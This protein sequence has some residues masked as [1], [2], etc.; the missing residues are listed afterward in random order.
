LFIRACC[1]FLKSNFKEVN[2]FA[3]QEFISKSKAYYL[4]DEVIIYLKEVQVLNSSGETDEC[5]LRFLL[6]FFQMKL[7]EEF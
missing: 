5:R 4:R 2:Q 1:Y 7:D 3:D 6:T